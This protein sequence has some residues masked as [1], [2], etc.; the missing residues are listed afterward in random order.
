MHVEEGE[1]LRPMGDPLGLGRGEGGAEVDEMR[2]TVVRS[3]G[4]SPRCTLIF[5]VDRA[6]ARVLTSN[7][8]GEGSRSQTPAALLWLSAARPGAPHAS[9]AAQRQPSGVSCDW[10]TA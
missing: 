3:C 4:C 5:A 9:T 2:A 7:C 1:V 10:P 8:A 6:L